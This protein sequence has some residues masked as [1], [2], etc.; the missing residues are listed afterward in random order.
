MIQ[1]VLLVVSHLLPRLSR[2]LSLFVSWLVSSV[3]LMMLLMML[4]MV[5]LVTKL[6]LLLVLVLVVSGIVF[7]P[8]GHDV[9]L[10]QPGECSGLTECCRRLSSLQQG[11]RRTDTAVT[12]ALQQSSL[13]GTSSSFA[14]SHVGRGESR[15]RRNKTG[16]VNTK[17][18]SETNSRLKVMHLL[19]WH[20]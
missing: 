17:Y 3:I 15:A 7:T 12:A 16:N 1:I 20:F 6:C 14:D 13:D 11:H 18:L 5:L 10:H 2:L 8:R 4:L 9:C 19:F